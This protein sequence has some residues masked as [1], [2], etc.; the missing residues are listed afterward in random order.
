MGPAALCELAELCFRKSI[1]FERNGVDCA[2]R[3]AGM[4]ARV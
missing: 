4:D 1:E 3:C 2:D